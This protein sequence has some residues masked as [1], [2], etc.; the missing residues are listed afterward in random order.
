MT[1]TLREGTDYTLRY[2]NNMTAAGITVPTVK[3]TGTGNYSGSI[4]EQ[5]TISAQDIRRL[6]ITVTDKAYGRNKKGKQYYSAPKVYDLDGKQL[7]SGKDYTVQYTY[8]DSKEPI[9]RNDK[10]PAGTKLCA[11]ITATPRNSYTGTADASYFVREAREVK[12]IAKVKNDKIPTQQ[13]TGSAVVPEVRLYMRNGQT[14]TYL[15]SADYEIIGCY[16]NTKRGTAVLLI[17]GTGSYSGVKRI[18]FKIAPKRFQ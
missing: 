14:K 8:A 11:V 7:K 16:N 1:T 3:I 17:R 4:T 10:I 18:T 9:G 5:F 13:Y 12:D 15:T 2:S 6:S